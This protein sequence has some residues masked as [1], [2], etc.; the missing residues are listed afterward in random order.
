MKNFYIPLIVILIFNI[1]AN[2][3]IAQI[4]PTYLRTEYKVNPFVDEERPRLSWELEGDGFNKSQSAYEILVSSSEALLNAGKGDLWNSSKIAS[5]ETNQIEYKGKPLTSGQQVWWKV[6]AW[7]ERGVVGK[8]SEIAHW[9][10][11][12]LSPKVWQGKWIGYDTNPLAKLGGNYHLPPSPYLRKTKN[13]A[14]KI[15]KARLYIA[16]LGLHE[17]YIN[18]NKI[19]NDYFSSGWTDYQKRVYYNVYDVT[20]NIAEGENVFGAIL[21]P[22]W[23]A[24]YLGYALLVGS[25]QVNQFYGDYPVMKAQIEL[26][27]LDGSKEIIVTDDSWK[28]KTGAI[29]EADFLQGEMHDANKELQ[30]WQTKS[31]KAH[32]WNNVQ[33]LNNLTIGKLELYPS[34]PVRVVKKLFPKSIRE[35]ESKKFIVDFGQNFAG[36][37]K[38]KVKGNKGDTLTFRYGEMCHPD[39]RLMTENMRMARST[40]YYILRGDP[41]GEIWT[42]KF[43]FHG[44]QYV[45]VT[46]LQ[47]K[48]DKDFIQG[49]V[50][51]SDLQEVGHIETDSD[52]LNQLYSN[53]IWTQRANY[54]DIPTDCPQ[55]DE[56]LG[57]TGD[58]Q[59]YMRSALYNADIAPFHKK[60]IQDLHDSQWPNGAYPVYAPM[61]VNKDG[62]AAIRESDTFS[63]GWSEAGIICTYEIFKAYNDL[64]LVQESMHY[65]IKFMTFL[66]SR[67]TNGIFTEG[68]FEDISPKGGFADWLSVGKKTS[69][70]LLA[71]IYY[72]YCAKLMSEMSE[73]I[74]N[75]KLKEKYTNSA[76]KIKAAF[77]QHYINT[78]SRLITNEK[79]YGSGSGYVDG[80][81]GFTGHTQTGY[82]NAIYSEILEESDLLVA[83]KY[84]QSLVVENNNRLSTGFLGF[85][86]LLPALSKTNNSDKAYELILSTE[87]PSLGYEV[88]NGATTIWER[89]DSYIKGEGFRHNAAMNSFSHYAFGAVNEWMFENMLGIKNMGTGYK[90][91]AIK[92]EVPSK[93]INSA[94]GYYRAIVGTIS[95]SWTKNANTI[96]QKIKIPV[97]VI[98][99]CYIKQGVKNLMINGRPI[100]ESNFELKKTEDK[101][102]LCIEL[103][104]GTYSIQYIDQGVRSE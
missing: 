56:R 91:I 78:D 44:F 97:N 63:P 10:M 71:S 47:E 57:W 29:L 20:T 38:I 4:V 48:P 49:L 82:A 92:P 60:W 35:Q 72:F 64:R 12:L 23:Y 95:S 30:G 53:I 1:N 90:K 27:Y 51:S 103:G 87:Y 9:E 79:R 59:I 15:A 98:A 18:G 67:A 13:I 31:Y 61:P 83:G 14:N 76:Q 104:S 25:K 40:D 46:G 42:P 99:N 100:N 26:T 50:L 24:G 102:Y 37:I 52:M 69:P 86:P 11:G 80:H 66:E 19:G 43:T 77:K 33:V 81:L 62:K 96:T 17:F 54:L 101:G 16:S 55:R 34:N 41:N 58:A 84:L 89:W 28:A 65:M 6:R 2:I 5:N 74:G 21:A 70:D 75:H 73:A 85:K 93:G 88:I 7:D 8:W 94:E 32:D 45:E 68:S 39:G 36:N 22:G 3:L